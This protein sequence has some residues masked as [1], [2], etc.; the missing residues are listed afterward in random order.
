MSVCF[1]DWTLTSHIGTTP[2]WSRRSESAHNCSAKAR[3]SARPLEVHTRE[4]RRATHHVG[5]RDLCNFPSLHPSTSRSSAIAE[6]HQAWRVFQPELDEEEQ[7]T[8]TQY[9][10]ADQSLQHLESLVCSHLT[11]VCA[12]MMIIIGFVGRL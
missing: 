12:L 10:Q 8:L 7:R 11:C 6:S 1:D 3:H 4:D 9:C 2:G 5:A